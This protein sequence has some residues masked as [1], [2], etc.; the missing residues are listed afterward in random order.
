MIK[1]EMKIGGK[2]NWANQ[3]ERLIYLGYNFSG[4][5]RWHQFSL[6]DSPDEVWSEI[7]DSDLHFIEESSDTDLKVRE[8]K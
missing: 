2:Y 1:S 5:G 7:L 6:I 4:N 3:P 8:I